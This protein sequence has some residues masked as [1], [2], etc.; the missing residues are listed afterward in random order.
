MKRASASAPFASYSAARSLRRSAAMPR[1]V[2]R[3]QLD[4]HPIAHQHADEIPPRSAGR[5]RV[6]SRAA[7]SPPAIQRARQRLI[8]VAATYPVI[9]AGLRSPR[10]TRS[11]RT[12]PP[13]RPARREHQR[14]VGR[15]GD[16]VL[17]VRRQ[18]AVARHR[19]PPVRQHL[20]LGPAH[21]H[22]RLDGEHHALGQPRPAPGWP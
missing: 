2:A 10:P 5:A 21:G 17:E 11:G 3:R 12:R 22:H 4:R 13:R 15:H 1:Q 16:G 14:T 6:T 20:R 7:R 8:T 19:R 9:A 18:A